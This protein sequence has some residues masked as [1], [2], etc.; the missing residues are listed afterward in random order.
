L[1]ARQLLAFAIAEYFPLTLGASWSYSGASNGQA[2]I[3]TTTSLAD[4]IE[5]GTPATI[6]R[7]VVSTPGGGS[8]T[9]AQYYHLDPTGLRLLREDSYA[10]AP[11]GAVRQ[12]GG[13]GAQLAPSSVLNGHTVPVSWSSLS[14]GGE[15]GLSAFTSQFTGTVATFGPVQIV[16]PAG[17]FTALKLV[18]TGTGSIDYADSALPDVTSTEMTSEWL[19]RGIGL[20]RREYSGSFSYSDGQQ[21]DSTY[22][23]SLTD[24]SLLGFAL[25]GNGLPIANGDSTPRAADGTYFGAVNV[26]GIS[27]TR[28][29]SIRNDGSTT[30]TINGATLSGTHATEFTIVQ[31]PA[32]TLAPGERTAFSVRFDPTAA[33]FR[34]ANVTVTSS[35]PVASPFRIS[36]RGKGVLAP[37]IE[38]RGNGRLILVG[39][40]SP[41]AAD[42]TFLG[43]RAVDG[44]SITRTFRIKNLGSATLDL[45]GGPHVVISG[46]NSGDFSV[47]KQPSP[48][49]APGTFT[50]FKIRFRPT[51]AEER[52]AVVSIPS[53][54]GD[55]SPYSFAISGVGL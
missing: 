30:M 43:A 44:T 13:G 1:E 29:F 24:S 10:S 22:A 8:H 18:R 45:T 55:E 46:V 4:V 33:G 31:M 7:T 41:R 50:T 48:T 49:V 26:S 12:F 11:P 20:V 42:F 54:D 53:N 32:T 14:D 36:I 17:T 39:D 15:S 2:I 38:V 16:T 23:F 28:Q 25:T 19:V 51:G 35:D 40:I 37:E 5:A 3:W 52:S 47:T 9:E 34:R 21:F 6:L 27:R